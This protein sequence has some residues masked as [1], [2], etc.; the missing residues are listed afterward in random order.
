MG[1]D[2]WQQ[3]EAERLVPALAFHPLDLVDQ[4]DDGADEIFKRTAI[5]ILRQAVQHVGEVEARVLVRHLGEH[6]EEDAPVELAGF[7]GQLG[8]SAGVEQH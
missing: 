8:R 5:C 4:V 2:P 6:L 3:E 1:T 7:V